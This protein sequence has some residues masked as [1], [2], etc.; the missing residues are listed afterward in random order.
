[1]AFFGIGK[2]KKEQVKNDVKVATTEAVITSKKVL[3]H[4]PAKA[5]QMYNQKVILNPRITEKGG[6]LAADGFYTFDVDRKATKK[7]IANAVRKIYN[8][9]PIRVNVVPIRAKLVFS[10]GKLGKKSAGKKA[11]VQLKEGDKIEFV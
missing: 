10:R 1:M 9:T 6:I 4:E 7:Q 11:Y 5:G 3:L 2:K 8:V